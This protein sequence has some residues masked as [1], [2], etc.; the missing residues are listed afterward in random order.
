MSAL[1]SAAVDN[2]RQSVQGG[3]Q[4]DQ[5]EERV[6]EYNTSISRL[7]MS[8]SFLLRSADM[9][10]TVVHV[11]RRVAALALALTGD[12]APRESLCGG[13]PLTVVRGDLLPFAVVVVVGSDL[14]N[15]STS[16]VFAINS[17]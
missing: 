11:R 13:R 10:V 16:A 12:M 7:C 2:D 8:S 5:S 6:V 15:F 4:L 17:S 14:S 3:D 9:R 1:C